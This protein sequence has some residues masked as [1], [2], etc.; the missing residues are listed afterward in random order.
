MFSLS[1][2]IVSLSAAMQT[3]IVTGYPLRQFY[4]FGPTAAD[5]NFPA[6]DDGSTSSIPISIPFS[7]FGTPH[8]SVYVSVRMLEQVKGKYNFANK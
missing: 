6:N 3:T 1:T 4:P 2:F 8:S 5:N 7:F